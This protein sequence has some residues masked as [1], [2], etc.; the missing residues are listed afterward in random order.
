MRPLWPSLAFILLRE[1]ESTASGGTPITAAALNLS[2]I[3]PCEEVNASVKP[4]PVQLQDE[5]VDEADNKQEGKEER[6]VV[7]PPSSVLVNA[8]HRTRWNEWFTVPRVLPTDSFKLV[9]ICEQTNIVTE[10]QLEQW[11]INSTCL[12]NSF[13]VMTRLRV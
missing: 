3:S 13:V 2:T 10:K 8:V 12:T 5:S 1:A 7:L 11:L 6:A 4:M 9:K